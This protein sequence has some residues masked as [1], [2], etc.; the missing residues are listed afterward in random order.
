MESVAVLELAFIVLAAGA[1]FTVSASVGLG[2]SLLLVPVLVL[3]LG[4][5]EGVALAALLLGGNNI[6]KVIAY[7]RTIPVRAAFM[8][9]VLVGLGAALG[10]SVMV[11][12]PPGI[13][14][15]AVLVSFAVTLAFERLEI[16]LGA[17]IFA[18]LLAFASGATSGFS[19]MSGPLKGAAI[20]NLGLD[21]MHFAGAAS[22]A[23]LVGDLTKTGIFAHARILDG[24]ALLIFGLALPMMAV[25][26][27][28]GFRLNRRLGETG[29]AAFFWMI[30]A[31]Y[32][33]RLLASV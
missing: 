1:A 19:G 15:A 23:S 8:V 5:R 26:T 10:A 2:G 24:Q 33:L 18:P 30:M 7:R 20:R 13:V 25:G 12:A 29:F 31:G 6:L 27:L 22:A 32:G 9:I 11:M 16:G 28:S 14:T 17:R 4:A 3:I 21:R